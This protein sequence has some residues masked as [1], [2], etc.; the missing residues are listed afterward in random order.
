MG[1]ALTEDECRQRGRVVA[2]E[3]N[4]IPDTIGSQLLITVDEGPERA[5]DS[6]RN[7][8][9]TS[10]RGNNDEAAFVANEG[11]APQKF[12]SVGMVVEDKNDI[13]GKINAAYCDSNG[14]PYADIRLIRALV[15][16]DPYDDPTGMDQLL[17][18][19]GVAV[20]TV[21]SPQKNGEGDDDA[22]LATL[23]YRVSA[24]PDYERPPE[25]KVEIRIGA[26]EIVE[27]RA[28]DE[29]DLKKMRLQEEERLNREDKSRAVVLE[30]LGD[31]PSADIKAPENVLFV[32][33]LNSVTEDEDLELIF[34]R[35]DEKVSVEIVRDHKTGASLQYAFVEFT[36]KERAAEAYFK[37][38]NALVD[39]RRIKID[40]SQS[41]SKVWDRFNQR[42]RKASSSNK[43]MPRD[44]FREQQQQQHQRNRLETKDRNNTNNDINNRKGNYR[45]RTSNNYSGRRDHNHNHRD[46]RFL[47]LSRRDRDHNLG[48]NF[49]KGKN[50]RGGD[51]SKLDNRHDVRH[52]RHSVG[53]R[54]H[55]DRYD[56]DNHDHR[57]RQEGR[58]Y[59]R[60][61][62]GNLNDSD[63]HS[64]SRHRNDDN[65]KRDESSS[66]RDD[67][68]HRHDGDTEDD[69]ISDRNKRNHSRDDRRHRKSNRG[70]R[71]RSPSRSSSRSGDERRT[72]KHSGH[73]KSRRKRER[74]RDS[75]KR[76]HKRDRR[77]RN[78]RRHRSGSNRDRR[79]PSSSRS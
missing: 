39:D 75:N 13:L 5:L 35:F 31:L 49:I 65:K 53:D 56:R 72:H 74:K 68:N 76:D 11:L 40:F 57:S 69:Y 1:R 43:A 23:R 30:M 41:V 14:R 50:D 34:S 6:F 12:R 9:S 48:S 60:R 29:E 32:C 52:L 28:T 79:S 63:R 24:S 25:E 22:S 77:D 20:A 54:N 8:S 55:R 2:T 21:K 51:G 33:K 42:N 61:D 26:D 3:M 19:R 78:D 44:P 36:T 59:E 15:I 27:D 71:R 7:S 67:R 46:D 18:D 10:T 16:D 64:R 17:E 47:D 37:M 70:R 4:G 73:R 38:N 45:T 66:H 62:R 58:D